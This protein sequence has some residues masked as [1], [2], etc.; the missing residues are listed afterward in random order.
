MGAKPSTQR[1]KDDGVPDSGSVVA[2]AQEGQPSP[3][4]VQP[5]TAAIKAVSLAD[6][7]NEPAIWVRYST[8]LA[9]RAERHKSGP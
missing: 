8:W 9:L 4:A 2:R 5:I 6:N 7:A 3:F 1:V